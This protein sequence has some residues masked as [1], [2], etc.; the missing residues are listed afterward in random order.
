MENSDLSTVRSTEITMPCHL[1]FHLRVVARFVMHVRQFH[2]AIR[3][4]KGKLTADG[5]NILG[6]LLLAVAWKSKLS[7]EAEGDDAEKTI[8][9][10]ETFFRTEH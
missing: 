6:L 4:R 1:G 3:V 9:G 10:I 8:Q 2:S 5:K 7:V